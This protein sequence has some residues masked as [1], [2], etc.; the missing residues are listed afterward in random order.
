VG[1]HLAT[2]PLCWAPLLALLP[3][4]PEQAAQRQA[5]ERLEQAKASEKEFMDWAKS[6]EPLSRCEVALDKKLRDPDS[7]KADWSTIETRVNKEKKTVFSLGLSGRRMAL[8][9]TTRDMPS[10]IQGQ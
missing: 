10:A 3:E 5:A 8:A 1:G 2:L 9:A 4:T 7:Y 6:V